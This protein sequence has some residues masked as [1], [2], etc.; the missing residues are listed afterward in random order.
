MSKILD[1]IAIASQTANV[2]KTTNIKCSI[3]I[4]EIYLFSTTTVL[5]C[6]YETSVKICGQG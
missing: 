2:K 3:F 1:S 6:K 4:T 5:I